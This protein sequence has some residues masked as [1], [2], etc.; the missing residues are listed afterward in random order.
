MSTSLSRGVRSRWVGFGLTLGLVCVS[1]SNAWARDPAGA[2]KLYDDGLKL[3]DAGDWAKACERF[4]ASFVLDPAPGTQLQ[5]AACAEHE[6]KIALAWSRFKE[7]RALNADTQS[8]KQRAELQSFIDASIQRL[9]PRLPYLSV[10]LVPAV[11]EATVARDGLASTF[12][13]ELPI[14]PGMHVV[15]VTAPGYAPARREVKLDEGKHE[16]LEIRL[17]ALVVP[18]PA[19]PPPVAASPAAVSSGDSAPTESSPAVRAPA[20]DELAKSEPSGGSLSTL[21]VAGLAIGGVGL[22]SLVASAVTGGLALGKSGEYAELCPSS[23]EGV[24]CPSNEAANAAATVKSDGEMLATIS[25]A[26]TFAG[27]GLAGAGVVLFVLGLDDDVPSTEAA[28]VRPLAGPGVAGVVFGGS[29][30]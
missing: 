2:E 19:A 24:V 4:E 8:K 18:S 3:L 11:K 26:T 20:S 14:D 13:V 27:I 22:A 29:F 28:Y 30:Q 21:S 10:R 5:R 6:G 7:A 15:E 23:G 9:E 16:L 25:T 17:E 12:D 1:V